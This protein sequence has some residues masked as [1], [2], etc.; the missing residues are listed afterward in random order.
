MNGLYGTK[1]GMTHYYTKE[2]EQV[3]V[4]V[5]QTVPATVVQVLTKEKHGYDAIQAGFFDVKEKHLNKPKAGVFH[6]AGVTNKKLLCE[7]PKD[8]ETEL[9]KGDTWDASIFKDEKKIKVT[10]I[11]KGHGFSG[12]VKRYGF[13]SSLSLVGKIYNYILVNRIF[14]YFA[15]KK[16]GR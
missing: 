6:A 12:T 15:I 2:G 10:S 5:I 1:L 16:G 11:S 9:K 14:T 4:T 7:F 8:A 3:P 13:T